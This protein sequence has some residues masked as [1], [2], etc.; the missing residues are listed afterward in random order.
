MKYVYA[1][2]IS[3]ILLFANAASAF[4]KQPFDRAVF[5]SLQK[6]GKIV[7]LD[8]YAPWCPTCKKQHKVIAQYAKNHP[9]KEF[10]VLIID[11]DNDKDLVKEF[12][13]PRQSTL[14]LYRGTKQ[15]WYSVAETRLDVISTEL[16]KAIDYNYN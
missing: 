4:E 3:T 13:A 12:R 2:F 15:F 7:L 11:Y 16:N 1:L 10:H 6:Q 8:V 5:D 9:D 14:L